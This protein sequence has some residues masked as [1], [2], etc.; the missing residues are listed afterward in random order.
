MDPA[1]RRLRPPGELRARFAREG[2]GAPGVTPIAQC[3]SGV[4]AC[5]ALL[6]LE[7]AGIRGGKLYVGSWSDWISDRSRPVAVGRA[8][9][10]ATGAGDADGTGATTDVGSAGR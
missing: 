10:D 1:T 9:G 2:L 5:H 3:G 6:A 4:T 8:S 7:L